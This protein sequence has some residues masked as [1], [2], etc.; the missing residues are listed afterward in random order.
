MGCFIKRKM[1]IS[2]IEEGESEKVDFQIDNNKNLC[3]KK[4][5]GKKKKSNNKLIIKKYYFIDQQK[6]EINP[7]EIFQEEN[8]SFDE[9]NKNINLIENNSNQEN[10]SNPLTK[11]KKNSEI[12]IHSDIIEGIHNQNLAN[13]YSYE[14]ISRIH[15][16]IVKEGEKKERNFRISLKNNGIN[17]WPKD[18]CFLRYHCKNCPELFLDAVEI[19]ELN[20]N[21]IKNVDIKFGNLNNCKKG[22]YQVLFHVFIQGKIIGQPIVIH[23]DII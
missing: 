6:K 20:I 23:F 17:S 13:S 9:Y 3:N 10:N 18:D 22:N 11:I 14:L 12:K 8:N 7:S 2:N 16:F 19:W 15:S 4:F 21:D 5:L 1:K